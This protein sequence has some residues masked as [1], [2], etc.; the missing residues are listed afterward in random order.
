MYIHIDR[1]IYAY[2]FRFTFLHFLYMGTT[3]MVLKMAWAFPTAMVARILLLGSPGTIPQMFMTSAE[4]QID[5]CQP[6]NFS[7]NLTHNDI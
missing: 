6:V 2:T 4:T 1:C 3:G 7:A 5:G